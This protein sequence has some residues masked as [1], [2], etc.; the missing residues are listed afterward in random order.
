TDCCTSST[1]C[2]RTRTSVKCTISRKVSAWAAPE[3]S[4]L[5]RTRSISSAGAKL[6]ML[7]R[8]PAD[9]DRRDAHGGLPHADRDRLPVLAAGAA[10]LVHDQVGAH[11]LDPLEEL[12][13]VADQHG[14]P[15][16]AR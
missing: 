11:P 1:S 2:W 3:R 14:A 13:G 8:R 6:G 7:D 10:R 16:R 5:V 12:E 9:R 4:A 15:D